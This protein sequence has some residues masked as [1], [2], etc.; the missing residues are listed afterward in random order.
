MVCFLIAISPC[1]SSQCARE[2]TK[3]FVDLLEL[4]TIG[5]LDEDGMSAAHHADE[6][7]RPELG[8]WL[9]GAPSATV[10]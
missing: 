5:R 8:A 4:P 6:A 1:T 2:T 9:R 7:G 10:R 3:A